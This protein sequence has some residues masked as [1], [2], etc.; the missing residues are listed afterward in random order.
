[1]KLRERKAFIWTGVV[2]GFA[3]LGGWTL[4]RGHGDIEYRTAAVDRGNVAYTISA[5]GSPNAV[6]TVQ[7]G[8][9]VSG[10]ILALFADFNSTVKKGQL[11]AR[12]D[13]QV[14]QAKVDQANA[15]L[16]VAK[17]AVVNGRAS[18]QRA[19]AD[20][21]SSTAGVANAKALVLKS[22]VG[23]Q[24]AH[25]KLNRQLEL[26]KDGVSAQQDRDTA[27]AVYDAAEADQE[28]V[29]AQQQAAVQK[30]LSSEAD[31]EV[32]RTQLSSA[33][34]QVKQAQ[35]SLSQAQ[36]DLSHTYIVAPV[37]GTV[38]SRNVD[39]GQTVAASLQAPTI[40]LIAQDLAKM[41]VDTNVS[42]ADV[43]RV[44]LGQTAT[45]TVDAYPGQIFRGRVSQIRQ[46][47][48]NVQNVITY[49]VVI[50]VA[51]PD[52][53]LFPGMTANVR[54]LVDRHENVL[55]IPNA[56]LRFHPAEQ[57]ATVSVAAKAGPGR[58]R[59]PSTDTTVWVMD[60]KGK[61]KPVVAQLGLSD[62]T[63]TEVAS[64]GLKEGDKV[65]EASFSKKT[66]TTPTSA[67]GGGNAGG[68]G[69]GPRF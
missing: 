2:A 63:Y 9:Q 50:T 15:S 6:V 61:P 53:K 36:L 3:V 42:E 1:M 13:P 52:L 24:D 67:P 5:T 49:D 18:V 55:R 47:P 38:V 14:F 16:D 34:A 54:I 30:V 11:V 57:A 7:V 40:F 59:G 21:A 26:F 68:P 46:A 33:E 32:A 35:A 39:V 43:G 62:G 37:D 19:Q 23:L 8:T 28:A 44:V 17:S 65:I 31:V 10:N 69:R 41:Q 58:K 27:Q 66:A 25:V 29:V 4:L 22:K 64:S 60:D 56:A 48:I 51:N 45:F 12:I 20:L